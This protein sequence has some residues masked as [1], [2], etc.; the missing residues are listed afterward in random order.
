[1]KMLFCFF[2]CLLNLSIL[3]AQEI[4]LSLPI[5][6]SS[7]ITHIIFSKDKRYVYTSSNDMTIKL[8]Y[9]SSSNI[10]KTFTGHTSEIK[11]IAVNHDNSILFSADEE[12]KLIA[13]N[14]ETGQMKNKIMVGSPIECIYWY[15]KNKELVVSTQNAEIIWLRYPEM[16]VQKSI[17]TAPYVAVKILKAKEPDM[18]FF[19]FKKCVQCKK[20]VIQ[21]GNVQM[22]DLSANIFFPLCTYTDDLNNL[23]LSPDS[24]KLI[25]ASA[26]NYMVRMWDT[27]K[28]IEETTIKNPAKPYA[29]FVSRTN[30]MIGV[31]S[32]ENGE[33]HIY[34]NSGEEILSTV[35][36]TGYIVYGEINYDI[37]RIHIL[38]NYGQFKKYDFDF[39]LKE[40]MGNY[41][42]IHDELSAVSY[43]IDNKTVAMGL[44]NGKTKLF[45]LLTMQTFYMPDSFN[46]S[47]K[48]ISISNGKMAVFYEPNFTFNENDGTAKTI[49]K[50]DVYDIGQRTILQSV[51]LNDKYIT[52]LHLESNL[53]FLGFN[54]GKIEI[55]DIQTNKKLDE[56]QV[57]PYDIL[58]VY[59]DN[60]SKRILVKTI[61]NQV[62]VFVY[63]TAGK[64][65]YQKNIPLND[66]D[67]ILSFY[68]ENFSS[69]TKTVFNS[70]EYS[71]T[72]E[73]SSFLNDNQCIIKSKDSIFSINNIDN[74]LWAKPNI[75]FNTEFILNDSI[76]KK[77]LLIDFQGNVCILDSRNGNQLCNLFFDKNTSWICKSDEFYDLD[78]R[79]ANRVYCVKGIT[80]VE[81]DLKIKQRKQG[82]LK[83]ILLEDSK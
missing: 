49:S 67:D 41:A 7:F 31:G 35:I 25:S 62:D 56:F 10:L 65:Q 26:E 36:D 70:K 22:Y 30:K 61:D 8:W 51:V 81:S 27:G 23:V 60:N 72:I 12:G 48:Q 43:S 73:L 74:V 45:D 24:T 32:G 54:N 21:R 34:R 66:N 76:L 79:L 58:K 5:K 75:F 71:H 15:E 40:V 68:A 18:Y 82:L 53:L 42:S 52:S 77:T 83:K 46:T 59:Y 50:Y 3:I 78:E 38:N 47:V 9:F 64:L 1:M 80:F 69:N 39:N 6:H 55:L 16:T 37:T 57:S 33:L 17:S 29:L 13:W 44:R 28:L 63:K 19:G 2:A 20:S 11:D 14:V 4:Q